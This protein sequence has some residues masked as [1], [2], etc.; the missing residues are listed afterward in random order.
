[1]SSY[2]KGLL[3]LNGQEPSILYNETNS[4]MDIAL[5]NEDEGIRV[6]GADFDRRTESLVCP[7]KNR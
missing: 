5:E 3:K 4:P 7:I 1:M 2:Q 6:Y